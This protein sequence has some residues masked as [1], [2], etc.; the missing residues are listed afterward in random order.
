MSPRTRRLR[1]RIEVERIVAIL[2]E[3]PLAPVAA[4]GHVMRDAGDYE[5]GKAGHWVGLE[6]ELTAVNL[7]HCHRNPS[8]LSP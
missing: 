4:L 6:A 3:R 8:A 5:A 2:E 1:Q 7:V